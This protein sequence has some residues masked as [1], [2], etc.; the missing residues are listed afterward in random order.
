MGCEEDSPAG[1]VLGSASP[2]Q[3][4]LLWAV[5]REQSCRVCVEVSP[6]WAG[7]GFSGLGRGHSAVGCVLGSAPPGQELASLGCEERTVLQVVC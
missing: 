4:W 2:G 1:C 7:A 5:K 6:F 3:V